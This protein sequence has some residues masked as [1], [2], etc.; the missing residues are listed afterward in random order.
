MHRGTRPSGLFRSAAFLLFALALILAPVTG[1][2]ATVD[3]IRIEGPI[4][5]VTA[6][7]I[8]HAIDGAQES[9]AQVLVIELDTPGGLVSTTHKITQS[10]LNAN[11]PV[12]VYVAPSGAS[13]TSAGVFLLASAHFAVM[14]PGT[15]AGA[16]HPVILEGQMDSTMSDKATNDASAN[17]RSIAH[18]HNRNA[19]WFDR[20]VRHSQSITSKEALDSNV[21]DFIA[22]NLTDLLDSLEGRT[23][24][25]PRGDVTL[26]TTGAAIN[27][28]LPTWR[29]KVLGVLTNP[30]IAYI[31]MSIG[32]IGILMELYNP[33][34]I[35]PGVIGAISLIVGFYSLQT[36]PIN[37][38]GLSLI[39]LAI[40]LF[41][42]ELK[43]VSH[44]LLTIGGAIAMIIGSVMLIDSP[45]PAVH[46]SFSVILAVVGTVV[47][48]FVFGLALAMKAR[49]L[50]P[51]TG[52]EGL[53]GQIGTARESF[54]SSGMVHVA[55]EYWRATTS[56]PVKA[57]DKIEV[58]KTNGMVL[59]VK[60]IA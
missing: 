48:F 19:E 27:R 20:A 38:A 51:T 37:Y 54:E 22:A 36:L 43:I 33:G 21:I 57:G 12:V 32:W 59:L 49:R 29:E 25:L 40:I 14:A 6:M 45:D 31:L 55:G 34:S 11:V 8:D 16:A 42:L 24:S 50:P 58:I 15:N 47:A 28:I 41:I 18:R 2:G 10:I 4:G 26:H 23:V 1:I 30:N 46:I 3:V 35:F 5:P 13:A 56:V 9:N 60:P 39:I 17:I 7:T 44:G 53:I 52:A